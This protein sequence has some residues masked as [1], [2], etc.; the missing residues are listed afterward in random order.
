[1]LNCTVLSLLTV[2]LGMSRDLPVEQIG[3][4]MTSTSWRW[5]ICRVANVPF[6]ES[7]FVGTYTMLD[8]STHWHHQHHRHRP[9]SIAHHHPSSITIIVII[10]VHHGCLEVRGEIIRTVLCCVLK[11]C[12]VISTLRWAVLTV[13]SCV[14][15]DQFH[16]AWIY[17][18]LCVCVFCFLSTAY[19]LYYCNTVRWIWW[20]LT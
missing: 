15:L 1:M 4:N 13:L 7:H 17:L 19:V 18:C 8:H 14:S 10:I 16:C 11:L 20:D 2:S 9:S 3:P 12:T 6:F 5:S